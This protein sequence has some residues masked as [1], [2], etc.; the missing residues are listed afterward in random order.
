MTNEGQGGGSAGGG[1]RRRRAGVRAGGFNINWDGDWHVRT[2]TTSI[3]W[4]AEFAI[5]FRTLR[6]PQQAAQLWGVNFQRNIRRRNETAYWA[7]LTR[8]YSLYRLSLA[9]SLA[10]LAIPRQRNLQI[11]PYVLG[12][13]HQS[14]IISRGT[15][16]TGDWGG[17]VK[18][19]VTPSLTLDGTYNTDFA[20]VEVDDQQ[21]NLDRFN[22]FFPE[23]RPFF[24]ENAGLFAVGAAREAE[25]FFSRRIGI[26]PDGVPIPIVAG[27][28]L[29][30]RV[31]TTDIGLLDIQTESFGIVPSN[32]FSVARINRELPN[33]S[34]IGGIVVNRQ[35]TGGVALPDDYNRTYAV[36][37]RWGVGTNGSVTGFAAKT[38][39]PGVTSAQHA[40][41]LGSSYTS[42][43]WSLGTHYMEVADRLQSRGGISDPRRV[44]QGRGKRVLPSS[45]RARG[46]SM[47]CGRTCWR[48]R[49][50][51]SRA[52][53]RRSTCT[54]TSTGRSSPGPSSIPG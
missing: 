19:S 23:K 21:I 54:S 38:S 3:G 1:W 51:T 42:Q 37:G 11:T 53:T 20:Q 52:S 7:P 43:A 13:S 9:G 41:R 48:A 27:G 39:T 10:G 34:A 15:R 25:V 31:G 5:P 6:Y 32:N 4:S 47:S 18:Y 40:Y 29:S 35:G 28:R 45:S 49:S 36:D 2:L 24:L 8:Q 44:P 22:L 12:E 17:D 33:R 46:H 16:L 50:G 30:G 26:A 14:G